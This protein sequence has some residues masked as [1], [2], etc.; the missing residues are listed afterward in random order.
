MRKAKA[1]PGLSNKGK[2]DNDMHAHIQD[3]SKKEHL[4]LL[5]FHTPSRLSVRSRAVILP[6]VLN[7]RACT[8]IVFVAIS[9]AMARV[10][11]NP[12][13]KNDPSP[14]ESVG[15]ASVPDHL[16]KANSTVQN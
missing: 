4:E 11:K 1:G 5:M 12:T 3:R 14:S 6:L 13:V 2:P 15:P 10:V 9:V 7:T 8:S 16:A